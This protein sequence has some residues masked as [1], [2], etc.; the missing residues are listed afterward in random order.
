MALHPRQA[1]RRRRKSTAQDSAEP[2][3]S[4]ARLIDEKKGRDILILDLRKLTYITDFF[5]IGSATNPRQMMAISAAI[6]Q[7]MADQG[8]R[9]LGIEGADGSRWVL[10][11]YSDFVVHIF[12]PEWLKIYDLEL[13]WGD[14][15]RLEWQMPA[16]E[17]KCE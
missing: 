8:L 12:D 4:C 7:E 6:Q 3:K 1:T 14:A 5:V 13:L 10:L 17:P 11:D 15:P 9:P 16:Q 2:A